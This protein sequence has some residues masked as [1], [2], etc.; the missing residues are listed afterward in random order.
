MEL[1]LI[2][3]LLKLV[4][5]TSSQWHNPKRPIC[6]YRDSSDESPT[7]TY[8]SN[9]NTGRPVNLKVHTTALGLE[10]NWME[11]LAEQ[12]GGAYNQVDVTSL[13]EAG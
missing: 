3:M 7:A 11:E 8:Y 5:P 4:P 12:T 6:R 9:Q 2:L 10:S 13:E 1:R